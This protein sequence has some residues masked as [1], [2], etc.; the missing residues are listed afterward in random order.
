VFP[1]NRSTDM[2][3]LG[4]PRDMIADLQLLCHG[5]S[6]PAAKRSWPGLRLSH[7]IRALQCHIQVLS[8]GA[9]PRGEDR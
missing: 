3:R 5:S 2:S 9:R 1:D 6:T 4:V 7:F 8:V